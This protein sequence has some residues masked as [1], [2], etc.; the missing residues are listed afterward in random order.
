MWNLKNKTNKEQKETNKQRNKQKTPR[1]LNTEG[2]NG[3]FWRGNG[4]EVG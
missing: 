3:G 4:W 1:L 2:K